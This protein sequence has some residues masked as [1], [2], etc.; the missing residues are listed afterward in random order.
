MTVDLL[1]DSDRIW[2]GQRVRNWTKIF[3]F[4]LLREAMLCS[5]TAA[6]FASPTDTV[7]R[8]CRNLWVKT[9]FD[10]QNSDN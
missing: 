2:L 10:A 6:G 7:R 3:L 5:N 9:A 8:F 1:S 4:Y